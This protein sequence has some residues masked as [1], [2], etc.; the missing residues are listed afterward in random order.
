MRK[1][2]HLET[3]CI[4]HND[5]SICISMEFVLTEWK[6]PSEIKVRFWT[7]LWGRQVW[8]PDIGDK[9]WAIVRN[10]HYNENVKEKGGKIVC[11]RILQTLTKSWQVSLFHQMKH[12]CKNYYLIR[13]S[14]KCH[15]GW[16]NKVRSFFGIFVLLLYT[17]DYFIIEWLRPS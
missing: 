1:K 7:T 11:L 2:Y 12:F 13:W 9:W 6:F 16:Y 17:G 3:P 8:S 10:G 5:H 14:R 15:N 4:P